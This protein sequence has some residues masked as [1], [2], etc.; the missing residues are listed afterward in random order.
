[1]CDTV[2]RRRLINIS[3]GGLCVHCGNAI[4]HG[5]TVMVSFPHEQETFEAQG[6]VIWCCQTDDGYDV[7]IQFC[8]DED[9]FGV[10]M[11]EQV[12][13][14]EHYRNQVEREEGR[15]LTIEQAAREWIAQYAPRF[16]PF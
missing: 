10:R 15:R 1:M 11:M 12:S 6:L 9:R 16:P 3:E 2:S 14:I 5:T 13:Q 8:S 4:A 7:G